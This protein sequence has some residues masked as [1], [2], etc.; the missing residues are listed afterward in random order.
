VNQNALSPTPT[1]IGGPSVS[2]AQETWPSQHQPRLFGVVRVG[3]EPIR[4]KE[5]QRRRRLQAKALLRLEEDFFLQEVADVGS[6]VAS[7]G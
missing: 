1:A 5:R 7:H 4:N 2:P 6:R 3:N